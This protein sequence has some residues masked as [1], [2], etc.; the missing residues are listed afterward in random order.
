MP[1]AP[2]V[3]AENRSIVC[4][5]AGQGDTG[6]GWTSGQ[7]GIPGQ[8]RNE[9]IFTCGVVQGHETAPTGASKW[10]SS[11]RK[12]GRGA[13]RLRG[14]NPRTHP[15]SGTVRAYGRDSRRH[16]AWRRRSWEA[17]PGEESLALSANRPLAHDGKGR[18][19]AIESG[20]PGNGIF[21]AVAGVPIAGV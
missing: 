13:W 9:R 20:L 14:T 19:E 11:P 8:A 21:L 17:G 16:G 10:W 5:D 3:F 6:A 7:T 2:T 18:L 4:L 1:G 15:D 12:T